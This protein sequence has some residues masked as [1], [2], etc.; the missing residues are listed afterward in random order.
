M[1]ELD[2]IDKVRLRLEKLRE[3]VGVLREYRLVTA[4]EMK[5]NIKIRLEVERALELAIEVCIDISKLVV[6]DQRLP[7]PEKTSGYILALGKAGIID[8]GFANEFS[9]A[10]GFRNIL[11]NVLF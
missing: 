11:V 4:K 5:E 9:K 1:T 6:T 7:I 10:A 3:L 2:N 8:F